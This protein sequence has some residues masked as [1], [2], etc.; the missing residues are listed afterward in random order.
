MMKLILSPFKLT[1][2]CICWKVNET[3]AD[4]QLLQ[5]LNDA[6]IEVGPRFKTYMESSV[7]IQLL[8]V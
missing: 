5:E 3:F 2:G 6:W 8:Q 4:L 1:I 7:E